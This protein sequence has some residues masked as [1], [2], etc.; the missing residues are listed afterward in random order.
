MNRL[1]KLQTLIPILTS[2]LHKRFLI[3]PR[4]LDTRFLWLK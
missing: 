1:L 2:N 3:K 4:Y